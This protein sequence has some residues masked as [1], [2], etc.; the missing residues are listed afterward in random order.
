VLAEKSRRLKEIPRARA[1]AGVKVQVIAGYRND[2]HIAGIFAENM[3]VSFA[4][5]PLRLIAAE[6]GFLLQDV[7]GPRFFQN[8]LEDLLV[9]HRIV[10]CLE[11]VFDLVLQIF[12]LLQGDDARGFASLK[13]DVDIGGAADGY[14]VR[15]ARRRIKRA[16]ARNRYL[17]SL[18][19]DSAA[20]AV[21]SSFSLTHESP[22]DAVVLALDRL[23]T[24]RQGE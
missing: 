19:V 10:D 24:K 16:S 17:R 13:I 6:I 12:V 7:F 20:K 23:T 3:K 2:Q 11:G 5:A 1:G 18:A 9:G 4:A 14:G 15:Q 21:E 8:D 22:L